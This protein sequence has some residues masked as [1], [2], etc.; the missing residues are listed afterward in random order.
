[1]GSGYGAST[2]PY[3]DFFNTDSLLF[4]TKPRSN[5]KGGDSLKFSDPLSFGEKTADRDPLSFG[6]ET[7][8]FQPVGLEAAETESRDSEDEDWPTAP[9]A[10]Y[11][12]YV[13][14]C[15]ASDGYP[16]CNLFWQSLREGFKTT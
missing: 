10:D 16:A 11:L 1:M 4:S 15:L 3:L 12:G 8:G 9:P 6:G 13:Q 5:G 14:V 7:S 2:D